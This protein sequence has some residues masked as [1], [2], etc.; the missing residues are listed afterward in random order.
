[1]GRWLKFFRGKTVT[2]G[3]KIPVA[4]IDSL[5]LKSFSAAVEAPV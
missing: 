4:F 2:V 3:G 5:I 1:V